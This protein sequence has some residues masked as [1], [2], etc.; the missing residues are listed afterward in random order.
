MLFCNIPPKPSM[1]LVSGLH[2]WSFPVFSWKSFS[3]SS[4]RKL[5]SIIPYTSIFSFI[6]P[7]LRRRRLFSALSF[8]LSFCRARDVFSSSFPKPQRA[9]SPTWLLDLGSFSRMEGGLAFCLERA[10]ISSTLILSQLCGLKPNA[11]SLASHW[12]PGLARQRSPPGLPSAAAR[13]RR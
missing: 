11:F 6:G 13:I 1:Q 2:F 3:I 10:A 12:D 8:R 5:L 7:Y 4:D 9:P